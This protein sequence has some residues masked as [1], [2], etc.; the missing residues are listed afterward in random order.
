MTGFPLMAAVALVVLIGVVYWSKRRAWKVVYERMELSEQASDQFALLQDHGIRC[1]LRTVP[2]RTHMNAGIVGQGGPEA[3]ETKTV[4][5]IHRNDLEQAKR[6][7][8]ERV[9]GQYEF[10]FDV[11]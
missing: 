5:E 10:M 7:L 2:V 6:L 1:R 11:S 4:V 3:V 9:E 8:D